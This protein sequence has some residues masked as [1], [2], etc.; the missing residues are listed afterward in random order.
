MKEFPFSSF[1]ELTAASKGRTIALFGAGNIATKT[2]RRLGPKFSFILDNNPA[3]WDLS[4]LDVKIRN[5]EI[6]KNADAEK[7]FIVICTTSFKEISAQLIELGYQPM[8]D[9][10]LSPILNDLRII[11]QMEACE[12]TLLFTSG[13]PPQDAPQ[14]GGGI[15]ELKL[16]GDEHEY[17]KI[18]SGNAHGIIHHK[19]NFIAVDDHL[20]VIEF[21]R[22]YKI[23]RSS[24]LP[25]GS[26][27]HG[28]AYSEETEK[29]YVG[30]SHADRILILDKNLKVEGHIPLS[31]KYDRTESPAH[32]CNDVCVNG[33]SLYISMFSYT[34]NWKQDIFDGVVV[35]YDLISGER[36]G[37]VIRDL[38]M[39]HNIDVIDGRMVVLDSLRGDMRMNNAG[40]FGTFSGFT[41][42]LGFDGTYFYVGQSR[43][44]NYS[45]N[46]GLSNN[47]SLDTS[48]IVFDPENKVSRSLSL[49]SKLSEI[50]GVLAV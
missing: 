44:R 3:M 23:I 18:I 13:A 33:T 21:D 9:F 17:R 10:M 16:N 14:Y 47:I 22:D 6:L 30:A 7:P 46:L 12:A 39:P 37:P 31:H 42:G 32:H 34:G 48:I 2:S 38:W 5:P 11:F 24:D 45:K 36:I 43:N 25:L 20:G 26:R 4:E 41:R 49:P 28:I 27:G 50:H 35:E 29:F 8:R 40:V 1:Q 15:Y 19:D